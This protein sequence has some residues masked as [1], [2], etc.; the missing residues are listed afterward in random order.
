MQ[1]TTNKQIT[2]ITLITLIT[3]EVKNFTKK[4]KSWY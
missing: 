2:L 4:T 1:Y 3:I